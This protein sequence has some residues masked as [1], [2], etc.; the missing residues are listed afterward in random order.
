MVFF[1]RPPLGVVLGISPPVKLSF[2]TLPVS[3]FLFSL[4]WVPWWERRL[5]RFL[6]PLFVI[7]GSANWI[8]RKYVEL[9]W[10]VP[11]AQQE[12]DMLRQ[13]VRLWFVFHIIT[14][15]VAWQYRWPWVV[16]TAVVVSAADGILSTP[17]V[18]RGAPYYVFYW[19]TFVTRTVS[20]TVVA[21]G[22]AWLLQ[23][24]REQEAALAEANRK[25]AHHAATIEQ[26]AVSQE[27][28][29]LARELH[30]TLAHSLSATSVQLE[31]AQALW[32][33]NSASARAMLQGALDNVRSGLTEARRA[34]QGLRASPLEDMDLAAA[35]VHLAR[36]TAARANLRLDVNVPDTWRK[37]PLDQ[38][39]CVY[40]V[41][42]EAL[43]NVVRHAKATELR[44][45]LE[46]ADRDVMLTVADNGLG[47]E[48]GAVDT[49]AHLGLKG[50]RERIEMIGGRLRIETGTGSGTMLSVT[51]P[52]EDAS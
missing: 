14:L 21:V 9:A 29:R 33:R 46:H 50:I 35:I 41:A 13:T 48:T 8:L 7:V 19:T 37:L 27:R 42:Q 22:V 34:L 12:M 30:D 36:S 47:F 52:V 16:L 1:P 20:V 40:R 24:Q 31:A 26:L 25:L 15:A 3:L 2:L 45:S 10:L 28:N 18:H 43:S 4:V 51:V 6:L 32:E 49:S 5:G 23:R 39:Q 17:F 44:V 11:P 38:E